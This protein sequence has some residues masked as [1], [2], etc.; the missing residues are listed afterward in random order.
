[1]SL[2]VP[3][4]NEVNPVAKAVAGVSLAGIITFGAWT[5]TSLPYN[6]VIPKGNLNPVVPVKVQLKNKYCLEKNP[7]DRSQCIKIFGKDA[8]RP[9]RDNDFYA[10]PTGF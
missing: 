8:F 6:D 4:S 5:N 2:T 3:P 9:V 1:M 7:D 10:G